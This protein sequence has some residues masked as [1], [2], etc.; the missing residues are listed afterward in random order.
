MALIILLGSLVLSAFC[1]DHFELDKANAIFDV[2]VSCVDQ[3]LCDFVFVIMTLSSVWLCTV[4]K[5]VVLQYIIMCS[6]VNR[7]KVFCFSL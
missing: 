6:V 3:L 4:I 5:V 7:G 2:T 1:S